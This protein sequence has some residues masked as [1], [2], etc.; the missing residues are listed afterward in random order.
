MGEKMLAGMVGI[1]RVVG[2]ETIVQNVRLIGMPVNY[3]QIMKD[4]LIFH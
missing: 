4:Y 1:G 3:Y 2:W